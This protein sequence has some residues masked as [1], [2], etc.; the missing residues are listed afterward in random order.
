VPYEHLERPVTVLVAAAAPVDLRVLDADGRS[1]PGH[2][3]VS[4]GVLAYDLLSD[5][6]LTDLPGVVATFAPATDEDGRLRLRLPAGGYHVRFEG[7][8]PGM[9]GAWYVQVDGAAA[10]TLELRLP[11]ASGE[12]S[13]GSL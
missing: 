11:A 1:P 5:P 4:D 10:R 7:D 13:G 12:P 9:L 2:L 6:L 8:E 3:Q